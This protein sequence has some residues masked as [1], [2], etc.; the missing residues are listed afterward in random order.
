MQLGPLIMSGIAERLTPEE[1]AGKLESV[2]VN[3]EKDSILLMKHGKGHLAISVDKEDAFLV[4]KEIT[5]QVQQRL[6]T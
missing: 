1:I 3:L 6:P 2:I 4:F 5:P